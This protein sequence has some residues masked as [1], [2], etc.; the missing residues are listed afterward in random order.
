MKELNATVKTIRLRFQ[1]KFEVAYWLFNR[2][3]GC[4]RWISSRI[5]NS[6]VM[7]SDVHMVFIKPVTWKGGGP[8]YSASPQDNIIVFKKIW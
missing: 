4:K 1:R 3:F 2:K 8:V 5:H 7:I 6:L